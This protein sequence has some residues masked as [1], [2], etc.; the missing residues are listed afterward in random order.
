MTLLELY[1]FKVRDPVTGKWRTT[2]YRLTVEEARQRYG[3]GNYEV[4]E[5]SREVRA[6]DPPKLTAGHLAR[7]RDRA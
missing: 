3:E 5:W 1:H 6:G 7:A 2:N 4:L